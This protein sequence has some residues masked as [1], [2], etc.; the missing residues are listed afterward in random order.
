MNEITQYILRLLKKK[1]PIPADMDP[2]QYAFIDNGHIDS[3]SVL[4][5]I[6]ELEEHFGIELSEDDISSQEFR[7][8]SGLA[9]IIQRKITSD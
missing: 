4:N 3:M 6:M 7:T 9:S 1:G 5:F 2:E 8:V